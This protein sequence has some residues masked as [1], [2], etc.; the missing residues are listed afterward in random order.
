MQ[1]MSNQS[2]QSMKKNIIY[3][4]LRSMTALASVMAVGLIGNQAHA[5]KEVGSQA[6]SFHKP[7]L[8]SM[9]NVFD[10]MDFPIGRLENH[11]IYL[12]YKAT[13]QVLPWGVTH[14]G[15]PVTT[16]EFFDENV[17]RLYAAG[18]EPV[19]NVIQATRVSKGEGKF[20]SPLSDPKNWSKE[21]G[22]FQKWYDIGYS[23]S[24]R[25]APGS[26]WNMRQGHPKD[27]GVKIYMALNE[28]DGD[29]YWAVPP[30]N[31]ADQPSTGFPVHPNEFYAL[32]KAFASGVRDGAKTIASQPKVET[33]LGPMAKSDRW[34]KVN[35]PYR[36]VLNSYTDYLVKVKDLFASGLISG[37]G[38]QPYFDLD[39]PAQYQG[40]A[41]IQ[42]GYT[43]AEEALMSG[44]NPLK[45]MPKVYV[46][47][48]NSK[49]DRKQINDRNWETKG[50]AAYNRNILQVNYAF[51]GVLNALS[52]ADKQGRPVNDFT[53]WFNPLINRDHITQANYAFTNRT[54]PD[55]FSRFVPNRTGSVAMLVN[56]LI[57]NWEFTD[58][59]FKSGI[60][61][62]TGGGETAWFYNAFWWQSDRI[63]WHYPQK[64]AQG[65]WVE[66]QV[67]NLAVS[68]IPE[69]ATNVKVYNWESA[70]QVDGPN[71]KAKLFPYA[72]VPASKFQMVNGKRTAIFYNMPL[73]R[74]YIFVA[75]KE[76]K[77]PYK[78]GSNWIEPGTR[79]QA[80]DF[81]HGG[82][83]D[84]TEGNLGSSD[85]RPTSSV[86][87][88]QHSNNPTAD[89]I[90]VSHTLDKES[91]RYTSKIVK[92]GQYRLKLNVA[93]GARIGG[94]MIKVY[95]DGKFL[96]EI[97]IPF[98][99]S[100]WQ[101]TK[102]FTT[103]PFYLAPGQA[104]EIKLEF[105]T[106]GMDL[107]WFE[108][109]R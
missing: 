106:G 36:N 76:T 8:E 22:F 6:H 75:D 65:Q 87:I 35:H 23:L 47:E 40:G 108:F 7:A 61:R 80:E 52:M 64:N 63:D 98:V 72:T 53:F 91:L 30:V 68:D 67:Q 1:L 101:V 24:A 97:T 109:V 25:F 100:N 39:L 38:L 92:P 96:T 21:H 19:I 10:V 45:K 89:Q 44:P 93:T 102:N 16:P 57:P 78:I 107:N 14:R 37:F 66:K 33:Y 94:K 29:W 13:D 55:A 34:G 73:N 54:T 71:T 90:V 60:H 105:V 43:R 83:W 26:D 5:L 46:G 85:Y 103:S 88:S 95:Q 50:T 62:L 2:D 86:D 3:K 12:V 41:Q 17:K 42:P 49:Y 48:T 31:G 59:N 77:A 32:N 4:S 58:I 70:R 20:W 79:I 74:A 99:D 9:T 51:S 82:H 15:K 27:W 104:S 81:D 69:G 11:R 56:T 18:A 84:S 28:V